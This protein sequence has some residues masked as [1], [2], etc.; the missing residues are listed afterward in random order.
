MIGATVCGPTAL[1]LRERA[2]YYRE[3]AR[4]ESDASK[5]ADYREI[6]EILGRE[7]E[8]IERDQRPQLAAPAD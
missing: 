7:A 8:G 2:S 5:A 1:W 6:A 3:R 4:K